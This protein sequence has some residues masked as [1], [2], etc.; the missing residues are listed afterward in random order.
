M[1]AVFGIA[2]VPLL[3]PGSVRAADRTQAV[4][5]NDHS[6]RS[7]IQRD[8]RP[9]RRTRGEAANAVAPVRPATTLTVTNCNN[10]GPGSLR[11]ALFQAIDGDVIDLTELACGNI[12]LTWGRLVSDSSLSIVGPGQHLLTIDGNA[13]D[14]VLRHTGDTL[15]ISGLTL[16]NGH[17]LDGFGG[18]LWATGDVALVDSTVTGCVAGDGNNRTAYGAGLDVIGTL[19]LENT[20]VR[21]NLARS[22]EYSRGGGIYAGNTVYLTGRSVV[23]GNTATVSGDGV[24]INARGGGMFA[25]E[26]AFA[27][28]DSLVS[29]NRV[30]ATGNGTAYGGGIHAYDGGAILLSS[31]TI[32]GN[33]AHSELA[34]SY[35]AGINVGN[36]SSRGTAIVFDST[37]SG[38]VSSANCSYCFLQGG[39]ANVFGEIS[40]KYS[41]FSDNHVLSA[42]EST[43]TSRGGAISVLA[44]GEPGSINLMQSTISG[45]S[46]R[47]GEQGDGSGF[48]GAIAARESIVRSYN[49]TIAFNTASVWGGGIYSTSVPGVKPELVLVSSIIAS[50]EAPSEADIGV[51]PWESV[52]TSIV[53]SNNLVMSVNPALDL[54][55]DTLFADPLLQPLAHNG[56]TT[57][58]HAIPECSPAIDAGIDISDLE[59]DQRAEPYV[60]MSA[61][62]VDIGAFELQLDPDAIFTYGFDPSPCP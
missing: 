31:A 2:A 62:G 52:P 10:A 18:C 24:D 1:L 56:G 48:G 13:A 42:V 39:G 23:S 11:D 57:A 4:R 30:E 15:E 27:I 14:I 26:G 46:V 45:N 51:P 28:E 43:G 16:A 20:I 32:S 17:S 8:D 41:T 38:N 7:R 12:V 40:S 35:G 5:S 29:A 59:F 19:Q 54:P 61:G 9:N 44:S 50:N 25:I 21:D 49:S 55:G 47:G 53:G 3:D 34:W 60:R 33:T 6:A 36:Y 58:T 22:R 37:I